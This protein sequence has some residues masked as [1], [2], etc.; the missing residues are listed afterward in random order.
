[1]AVT[2]GFNPVG[3]TGQII[4][5]Q[6]FFPARRLKA[7]WACETVRDIGVCFVLEKGGFRI[8]R[9]CFLQKPGLGRHSI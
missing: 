6:K 1:M 7:V 5:G 4:A 8:F 9:V 3:Q 2:I